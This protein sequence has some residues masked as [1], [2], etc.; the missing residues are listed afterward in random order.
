MYN[1]I[2]NVLNVLFLDQSRNKMRLRQKQKIVTKFL[3]KVKALNT[4]D[5]QKTPVMAEMNEEVS[6]R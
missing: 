5:L 1:D 4:R 6:R 2:S 3:Y